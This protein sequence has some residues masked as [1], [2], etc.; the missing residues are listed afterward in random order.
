ML[1][2]RISS[3]LA[4]LKETPAEAYLI[5]DPVDLFYLTGLKLSTGALFVS[6]K[7]AVLFVDGRY[8]EAAKKQG[9]IE[10]LLKEGNWMQEF[11]RNKHIASLAFDSSK[12]SVEEF[13]QRKQEISH[14]HWTAIPNMTKAARTIK[15]PEEIEKLRQSAHIAMKGYL[16]A[17]EELKEGVM[18]SEI[19]WAFEKYCREHG[20]SKLSFDTIVAFGDHSAF[21]HYRAGSRKYKRGDTVLIDAGCVREGYF[22]DMTRTIVGSEAPKELKRMEEIVKEAHA[23]ACKKCKVGVTVFEVDQAAREPMRKAG[24]EDY[25]T[26]NLGHGVGLEIH[27][28]P[29]ISSKRLFADTVLQENMV[30]TIEPGLYIPGIGGIRYEDT[31]CLTK[32]GLENFY[33]GLL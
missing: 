32:D 19:A 15:S 14:V 1:K 11:I 28:F 6:Q 20:A 21:P 25:F 5:D 4:T 16:F 12:T 23:A 3:F 10:V 30:F 26:H 27:E 9:H 29:V 7:E 33:V 8:F 31:V 13:E 24:M 18:E 2:N 22:S 17:V